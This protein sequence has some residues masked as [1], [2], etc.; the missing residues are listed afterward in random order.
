MT[1]EQREFWS[2]CSGCGAVVNIADAHN[3]AGKFVC[4]PKPIGRKRQAL[5]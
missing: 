3:E 2:F 1:A 5:A 4:A